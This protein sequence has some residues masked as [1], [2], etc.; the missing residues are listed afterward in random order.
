[1][2]RREA[3][4]A[5]GLLVVVSG[6]FLG[7]P[8]LGFVAGDTEGRRQELQALNRRFKDLEKLNAWKGQ[9]LAR[10]DGNSVGRAVEQYQQ[11][12]W[13][14]AETVGEFQEV[15]VSPDRRMAGG[16]SGQAFIPVRRPWGT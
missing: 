8:L 11:W 7:G 4:L 12:V 6:Y 13:D 14:V 1:M 5:L 15:N 10:P 3:I 16:R 9:S 2:K